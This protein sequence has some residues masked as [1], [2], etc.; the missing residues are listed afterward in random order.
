MGF[1]LICGLSVVSDFPLLGGGETGLAPEAP[2][3][4]VRL[5]A[6]PSALV[7]PDVA[8]PTWQAKGS[9]F[10][11]HVPGI[12]RLQ[13]DDGREILVD[14]A[15]GRSPDDASPFVLAT[16]FAALMHQRRRLILHAATIG[17]RG[18][19][20]AL[21]GPTG[22]GKSTLA[23]ALCRAGCHFLGDDIAAIDFASGKRPIVAADGRQHRLWADAIEHLALSNRKGAAVRG[24]LKKFHVAPSHNRTLAFAPLAA[25]IILRE[26]L[27]RSTRHDTVMQPLDVVDAAPTLRAEVYRKALAKKLG[28]D[29]H[30]FMQIAQLLDRVPAWRLERNF[31]IKNIDETVKII[32]SN[33][34][35]TGEG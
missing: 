4:V 31:D 33:L 29:A 30:L 27:P 21:C 32:L 22:A 13:V 5:A 11:L 3:V 35:L 14:P 25:V 2:D 17:W 26:R 18:Q 20:I 23:A 8:G 24:H 1:Y 10:L 9:R 7:D 19:A 15:V 6:L 16:G 12:V 28:L 34:V